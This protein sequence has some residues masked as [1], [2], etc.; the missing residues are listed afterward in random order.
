M[1]NTASE[2]LV[3]L[4]AQIRLDL[5]PWMQSE[6][7]CHE[8]PYLAIQAGLLLAQARV[9]DP[10]APNTGPGQLELGPGVGELIIKQ[11]KC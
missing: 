1:L 3:W 2:K 6:F 8:Q 4:S 10:W 5:A 9:T 7:S 11:A